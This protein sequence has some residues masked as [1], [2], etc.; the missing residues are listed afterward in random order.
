MQAQVD[1][2]DNA[3]VYS[4]SQFGFYQRMDRTKGQNQQRVTVRP[5][6]ELGEKPL[7]FNWQTP[8]LLSKHNQDIF[9]YGSNRFARSMNKGEGMQNLGGDLTGG[10][11]DGNVPFGTLTTMSESP[12]RFGLIY[13][14][15]DD[16]FINVSKDGGYSWT[17]VHP[18]LPKQL[19]G[20]YISRVVASKYKESRVYVTLNGYRNDHFNAYVFVSDDF[21][22]TWKQICMDLPA[23]PVNVI[24]EDPK[25]ENVLYIGTD[26]GLYVSLDAGATS[27]AWNASLPR[28]PV[29]DIAI[30]ERE[31]EI[32]LGTHGRSIYI[33]SLN[34][35]QRLATDKEY[36][37]KKRGEIK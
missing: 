14:G 3:T 17:A 6:H 29:H 5:N 24:R 27:M 1:T 23:E 21:G 13:T 28:V 7:R 33:A 18:K 26:N 19:Q 31:N 35:V 20:L 15:S 16:G 4:G 25:A 11:K 10:H 2:R 30:Q 9:Y 8:I 34:E 37:E 32:V 22:T 12:M 36:L